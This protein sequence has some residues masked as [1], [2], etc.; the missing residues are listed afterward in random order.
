MRHRPADLLRFDIFRF[1]AF[2]LNLHGS[3]FRIPVA[4]KL[5]DKL[6]YNHLIYFFSGR[7]LLSFFALLSVKLTR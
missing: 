2:S 6:I 1:F 4:L 7:D 3:F 5:M